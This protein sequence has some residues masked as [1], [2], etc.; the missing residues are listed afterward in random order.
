[1]DHTI[2]DSLV[3]HPLNRLHSPYCISR[4]LPQH[5]VKQCSHEDPGTSLRKLL[6]VK[7][8]VYNAYSMKESGEVLK[9]RD[10]GT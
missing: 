6:Q 3:H 4:Y 9:F 8:I 5:I 1:M 10:V 2:I 7:L